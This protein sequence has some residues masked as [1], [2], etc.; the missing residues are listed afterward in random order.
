MRSFLEYNPIAIFVYFAAVLIV[1]MF[2]Q[3]PI[4]ML[5]SLLGAVMLFAIISKGIRLKMILLW[6]LIFVGTVLINPIFS[7]KGETIL[8]FMNGKPITL[9]ALLYGMNNG[10]MILAVMVWFLSLSEIMTSDKIMYLF[11]RISPRLSLFISMSLRYIPLYRRRAG[12]INDCQKTMGLYK[13]DNIVDDVRGSM[14]VFSSLITWSI[15]TSVDTAD[16]FRARGGELKSRRS[17][18]M[19]RFRKADAIIIIMTVVLF[20]TVMFSQGMGVLSV[21]YYMSGTFSDKINL[22]LTAVV[23]YIAYFILSIMPFAVERLADV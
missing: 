6:I 20:G 22:G 16:S 19:F 23:A 7:H 18:S 9:E 2:V 12:N 21:D 17:F 8:L 1:A 13:E 15:E 10:L 11:G 5:I 4:I 3:N 14:R